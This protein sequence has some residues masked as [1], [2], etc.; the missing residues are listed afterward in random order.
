MSPKLGNNNGDFKKKT[1]ALPNCLQ[2][3]E[4]MQYRKALQRSLLQID[5]QQPIPYVSSGGEWGMIQLF[6]HC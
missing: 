2:V 3:N 5:T 6:N 1:I 4:G